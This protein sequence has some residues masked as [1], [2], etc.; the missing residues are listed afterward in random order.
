M[1]R[2]TRSTRIKILGRMETLM[3]LKML[4]RCEIK[5]PRKNKKSQYIYCNE[6]TVNIDL[7][8]LSR[9]GKLFLQRTRW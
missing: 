4:V 6:K 2:K 8:V 9:A 1:N 3:R 5:S 7:N